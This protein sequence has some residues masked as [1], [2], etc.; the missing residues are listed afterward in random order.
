MKNLTP[1]LIEKAKTV[2]SVEELLELA[3][4]NNVELTA[5][6]AATYFAQMKPKSGELDD[7]DL[8]AVAGGGCSS[9]KTG[10]G[11]PN[12]TLVRVLTGSTCWKCGGNLGRIFDKNSQYSYERIVC[13]EYDDGDVFI[14]CSIKGFTLGVEFEVV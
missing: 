5:E 1:E 8:D 6:D 3:K 7:D 2:A 4:A 10:H 13:K 11:V 14:E 12:G 9:K